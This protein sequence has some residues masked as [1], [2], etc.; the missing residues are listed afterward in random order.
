MEDAWT[1]RKTLLWGMKQ[2]EDP[3]NRSPRMDVETLLSLALSQDRAFLY[4]HPEAV[5]PDEELQRYKTWIDLRRAHYPVQYIRG[6]Q[7]FYGRNFIVRPGILIPRPETE[8]LVETCLNLCREY[9][10]ETGPIQILEIGTGS[11]CIAITLSAENPGLQIKATDIAPLATKTAA[12]NARLLLEN[13][14]SIDFLVSDL[15][16]CF[17]DNLRLDFIVSNPPYVAW[18]DAESVDPSVRLHEPETAVFSGETGFEFYQRIFAEMHGLLKPEGF[19]LLEIGAGQASPL[20]ELA[21]KRGWK[22]AAS[23]SDL[24]GITRCLVFSPIPVRKAEFTR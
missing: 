12:R 11:G 21:G 19:L 3:E 5:V 7:E 10:P 14:S 9:K 23:H 24:A 1:I 13:L 15:A 8:L 16:T 20:E 6:T 18:S 17:S 22:L 2:L 4:A